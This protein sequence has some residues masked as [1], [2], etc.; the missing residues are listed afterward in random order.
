MVAPTP[1]SGKEWLNQTGRWLARH[2][3][4]TL[5][6]VVFAAL[7]PF[8]A[9]PF[10]IDDPLFI[11]TAQQIHAHPADP[12]GFKVN[13]YG[14]AE[15]MWW[16]TQN[17]PLAGYYLALAAEIVGWS[18]FALHFAFLLPAVA[19]ILG[20]HRLACRFCHSPMLAALA[21]LFTPVFLV[22][23]T[24][25]MCDVT[26]LAFWI[27]AVVLWLEGLERDDI[28]R[29]CGAS[30]LIALAALT[31]YFG[32][33]LIPLLAACGLIE[34]RRSGR[35]IA[36]LL[37]PLA[38][39]CAYQWVTR[40]LYGHALLSEATD[41]AKFAKGFLGG[42]KIASGL[43]ALTFTGGCLAVVIFFAPRL[44][45]MRVLALFAGGSV[46]LAAANYLVGSLLKNGAIQNIPP[47]SVE[48]Q[49]IFWAVVGLG[50][51]A[52]AV[53]DVLGRRDA[54]SWL[55]ALWVWGT[56]LFAAF[57]NWTVN[58]RS[59]LPMVPA[60][61][62]LLARRWDQKVLTGWKTR[63]PSAAICLAT[64]AVLALLVTRADFCLA[65]AVR[66]SAQQAGVKY[67]YGR[68]PGVLWFQGHWGF[69]FYMDALGALPLD[70]R[71]SALKPGDTLV[72]PENNTSLF[73]VNSGTS[74]LKG[75]IAVSGPRWLTTWSRPAGAGFFAAAEGPLPFAFGPVPPETVSVYALKSPAP[76]SAQIPK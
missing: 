30:L 22:S 9:K 68:E 3:N 65:L 52:M 37:I 36:C 18:E 61:G 39:L 56:F 69:Q 58:G 13:W 17:P 62:I 35:W 43:T 11:W 25:V 70:I 74:A 75:T 55:L 20:T 29:L 72:V 50:V 59:L 27:W 23:A 60:V 19:A 73:P 31:K 44:W 14:T 21:T 34:K 63:P 48:F 10:N 7:A 4:W 51:L 47:I 1:P 42:P 40:A 28:W 5:L 66:Q 24:T 16:V 53:A 57:F 54:R 26:M 15:P 64:G 33:C 49:I 45:R 8:L 71:H 67:G 6:L 46:L 38:A 41:Y 32:A 2:P 12:Y 76:R